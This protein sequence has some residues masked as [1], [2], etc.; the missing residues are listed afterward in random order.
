MR[1]FKPWL[2]DDIRGKQRRRFSRIADATRAARD[3]SV[4]LQWLRKERSALS[5]RQRV[6]QTW[7]SERLEAQR[8]G[9]IDVALAAAADF[10]PAG[11][12]I[13]RRLGSYR[14]PVRDAGSPRRVRAVVAGTFVEKSE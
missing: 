7:L 10:A 14:A 12:K 13:T 8:S 2:R 6:G 5:A 1:A 4:H 11:P 9:G 3:A